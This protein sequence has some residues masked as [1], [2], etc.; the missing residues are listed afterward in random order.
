MISRGFI[1]FVDGWFEDGVFG[2]FTLCVEGSA[3]LG[4][5]LLLKMCNLYVEVG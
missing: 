3:S 2:G 5:W 4:A 1:D